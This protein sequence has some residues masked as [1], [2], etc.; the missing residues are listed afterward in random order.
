MYVSNF[1]F[2]KF[3]FFYTIW[4]VINGDVQFHLAL[5]KKYRSICSMNVL[6]WNIRLVPRS[7]S[8]Y[9]GKHIHMSY[10]RHSKCCDKSHNLLK[11]NRQTVPGNSSTTVWTESWPHRNIWVHLKKQSL[12]KLEKL[13]ATYLKRVLISPNTHHHDLYKNSPESPST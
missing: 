12:E 9:A 10:K 3:G 4:M 2:I 8:P 7:Y 11:V 13:K 1:F 6:I 5:N